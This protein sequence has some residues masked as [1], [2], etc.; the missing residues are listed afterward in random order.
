M[1]EF[2]ALT[3]C[4]LSFTVY[5]SLVCSLYF[6]AAAPAAAAPAAAPPGVVAPPAGPTVSY[7]APAAPGPFIDIPGKNI[8]QLR[9][10]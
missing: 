8:M 9:C 4:F 6:V 1:C 3:L 7:A 10:R 5:L 2:I